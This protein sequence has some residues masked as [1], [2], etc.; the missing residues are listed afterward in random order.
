[1]E[2]V[3]FS[4]IIITAAGVIFGLAIGYVAKTFA[5]ETDPRIEEVA[6]MLPG[7]NCGGC[8]FAGCADFAKSIVAGRA[9]P[10]LC[11]VSS[12]EAVSGIAKLMGVSASVKAPQVAV[13]FCG[14]NDLQSQR[15]N[16]NGVNDCLSASL[17]A[18]GGKACGYGCLGYGSCAVSCPFGAIQMNL[19]LAI[20][21]PEICTG[22]GK[23]VSVCPKKLI[24]LVPA[25]SDIHIF[26]SAKAKAASKRK[27]CKVACIACKKCVR[28]ASDRHM[29]VD[30]NL[31]QVNYANPPAADIVEKAG[32]PTGC[33]KKAADHIAREG[34][35]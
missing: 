13:V 8:G 31:V 24:R 10:G 14:G 19:G 12:P 35:P 9:V 20:I 21:H 34:Q 25:N 5:V 2:T 28:A 26:C 4:V 23:C 7:V 16:Y 33:L 30:L 1:M 3:I 22:C 17:V 29:H 18:L 6:G 11:P 32:C 27:L 15:I